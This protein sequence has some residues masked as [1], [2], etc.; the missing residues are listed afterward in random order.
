YCSKYIEVTN[1]KDLAYQKSIGALKAKL[2]T[3]CGVQHAGKEFENFV[4]SY[5]FEHVLAS[6]KHPR[7][8]A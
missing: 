1:L 4:E 2:V 5:S 3:D 8:N 7:A 6:P